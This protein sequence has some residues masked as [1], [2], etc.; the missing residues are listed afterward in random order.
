[1]LA[2]LS[3]KFPACVRQPAGTK[4]G[5]GRVPYSAKL[6]PSQLS[7]A[8][9]VGEQ[10][11]CGSQP[12]FCSIRLPNESMARSAEFQYR[13]RKL[14]LFSPRS[15]GGRQR[16]ICRVVELA[17]RVKTACVAQ[18][19]SAGVWHL[20]LDRSLVSIHSIAYFTCGKHVHPSTCW[21]RQRFRSPADEMTS[22]IRATSASDALIIILRSVNSAYA[23]PA[24]QDSGGPKLVM[25]I[26]RS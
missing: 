18:S 7:T 24:P 1:M 9:C 13:S 2:G 19:V 23:L 8:T 17:T 25:P 4:P 20:S 6:L 12:R 11:P 10:E 14:H 3:D 21:T 26:W 22:R 15:G 5:S 16:G